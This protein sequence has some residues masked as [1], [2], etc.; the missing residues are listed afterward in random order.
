MALNDIFLELFWLF[1][2]FY[3]HVNNIYNWNRKENLG[4]D[5]N[6]GLNISLSIPLEVWIAFG[7]TY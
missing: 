4:L 3:I 1:G 5:S 7:Y 2:F 6:G